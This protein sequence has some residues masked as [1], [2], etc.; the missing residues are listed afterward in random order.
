MAPSRVCR[1]WSFA[2]LER[3]ACSVFC[4]KVTH[5]KKIYLNVSLIVFGKME[6][7]IKYWENRLSCSTVQNQWCVINW[8]QNFNLSIDGLN[9]ARG[10]LSPAIND[11]SSCFFYIQH[12]NKVYPIVKCTN[13]SYQYFIEEHIAYS[14]EKCCQIEYA[15]T[16]S[17]HLINHNAHMKDKRDKKNK[18]PIV[19]FEYFSSANNSLNGDHDSNSYLN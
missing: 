11:Q 13:L 4:D 2:L 15:R 19:S 6:K 12:I 18:N 10:S 16:C 9:F 17:T 8:L 1:C 7:F 5:L 14:R 3:Y